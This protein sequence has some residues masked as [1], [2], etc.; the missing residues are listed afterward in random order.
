M[1]INLLCL[2]ASL[3]CHNVNSLRS[4]SKSGDE[5]SNGE[6]ELAVRRWRNNATKTTAPAKEAQQQHSFSRK[7]TIFFYG[8]SILRYA[9]SDFCISTNSDLWESIGDIKQDKLA[10]PRICNVRNSNTLLLNFFSFGFGY[11]AP[12]ARAYEFAPHPQLPGNSKDALKLIKNILTQLGI[13]VDVFF[14]QSNLWDVSRHNDWFKRVPWNKYTSQWKVNATEMIQLVEELFP[15]SKHAWI[16]TCDPI[17]DTRHEQ[18]ESLNEAARA[19]LP[20]S[21][22]Y[23][24]VRSIL[25]EP[26]D[27]RD[28]FHLAA[29]STIPFMRG[30]LEAFSDAELSHVNFDVNAA[31]HASPDEK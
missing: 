11:E 3:L 26:P 31:E 10:G 17:T 2:C 4:H 30:L 16:S 5:A 24:D 22:S 13:D 1:R 20:E 23:F 19:I 21:W 28:K 25:H 15:K 29:N 14:L 27:F 7:T 12:L 18:A 6:M 9:T 8:D